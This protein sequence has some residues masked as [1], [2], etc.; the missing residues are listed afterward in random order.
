MWPLYFYDGGE[1]FTPLQYL[2]YSE[3]RPLEPLPDWSIESYVSGAYMSALQKYMTDQFILRD[4]FRAL[5][6]YLSFYGLGLKDLNE[7]F[8]GSGHIFKIERPV[9]ASQEHFI[10]YIKDLQGLFTKDNDMYMSIIPDKTFYYHDHPY[11]PNYQGLIN[12][13]NDDLDH[14]EIIE[15]FEGLSLNSY[16]KTDPHWR[17]D[18]LYSVMAIFSDK[19]AMSLYE[20]DDFEQV[21]L[22]GF[23]GAY[24]G[25]GPLY[26]K[27]DDFVYLNHKDFENLIIK[28][29]ENLN[30]E[31]LLYDLEGY[32]SMDPYN[33]FLGG[34]SPLIEIENPNS[35]SQDHLIIFRD[36]FASNIGPFF[37][38]HYEKVTLI[39]TR[40][41]SK[42]QITSYVEI[43]DQD[44]LFLY[45]S[46]LVNNSY[47]LK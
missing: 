38:S 29:Y 12:A 11:K 43:S 13:L 21:V 1:F 22:N 5:K 26:K 9:Q 35:A 41:M 30:K 4:D 24:Y 19:M 6:H 3:R 37:L 20:A 42:D 18:G 34:G 40:Y 28:N 31:G 36:S 10:S 7:I 45:S 46:L 17:Q 39:D 2:S 32:E 16:Y 33:L 14:L 44:V 25:Q 47:S 8:Y 23:K 27:E 15:I